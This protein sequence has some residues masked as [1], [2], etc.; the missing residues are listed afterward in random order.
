MG[1]LAVRRLKRPTVLAFLSALIKAAIESDK[2]VR[3]GFLQ[4]VKNFYQIK[5]EAREESANRRRIQVF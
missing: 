5:N 2:G 3:I 1:T 4:S